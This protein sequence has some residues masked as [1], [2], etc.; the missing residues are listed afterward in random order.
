[1]DIILHINCSSC[2][3]SYNGKVVAVTVDDNSEI[4]KYLLTVNDN[5][6]SSKI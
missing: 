2:M 5:N 1:M 3:L 4:L 6:Q